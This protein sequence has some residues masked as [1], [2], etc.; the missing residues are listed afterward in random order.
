MSQSNSLTAYG[1]L[2]IAAALSTI[3]LKSYA[4]WL[5]DSVGLLSDA[6]ES[7]INLV[8]AI[9]MVIVLSVSAR[10]PD[11][12]HAYGHEKIEYFS[13]GAEGI[14]IVLAACS[15]AF[16]AWERLW[17]PQALQQLDLGI[18]V[19]VFASLI[20]LT[21]ARILIGVGRSRQSIT[22]EADGKHLM[23]DVW[24][25]VG[26]LGGIALIAVANR[27]D[28][29]LALAH[30]LGLAGW[31]VLD[32]LI[33]FLVA[34]QIVWAG[35]QLITRTV[36]GLMDAAMAPDEVREIIQ[37][38]EHYAVERGIAYHALRTRYAGARRFMSVHVL[39]PGGWSVQQGHDLL[40]EIESRLMDCFDN[41]D[42]DT[43]LEP[44]EDLASWEH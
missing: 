37:V 31:D 34:V 11:D 32:P 10:P 29:E 5:T 42:I 13:S 22:L 9:I 12:S 40:E 14:M 3:A 7:L 38:L 18:A 36:A 24:T 30:Q 16:A 43:H 44:I 1:W 41:I 23:T 17:H 6:L 26:I 15:I 39:V 19:S 27:Y 25:T 33:A 4:Y 20:N 2:S 35:F 28:R 8:A 21:V